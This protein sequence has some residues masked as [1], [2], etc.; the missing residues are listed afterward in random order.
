MSLTKS[1]HINS[2]VQNLRMNLQKLAFD[3]SYPT[4]GEALTADDFGMQDII[5]MIVLSNA[6]Y[7]F[8]YDIAN[9]KLK[10]FWVD[11][12]T[13]GSPLVEVVDTTD[14]SGVTDVQCMAFGF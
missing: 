12:T 3:S 7:V 11:T 8:E 1:D 4:G 13:D 9:E 14:L 2:G 6:G 10:A 5:A